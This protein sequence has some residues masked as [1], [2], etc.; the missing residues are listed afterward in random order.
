MPGVLVPA[1]RPAVALEPSERKTKARSIICV[2]GSTPERV[3]RTF[4]GMDERDRKLWTALADGFDELSGVT[5]KIA[6][7]LRGVASFSKARP[8]ERE[9]EPEPIAVFD[10]PADELTKTERKLLTALVQLGKAS[11]L[12]MVGVV[13]QLS[14]TAGHVTKAL[15]T[16]RSAGYVSG[17]VSSL[18][19]TPAGREAVGTV[20]PLPRGNELL[21]YWCNKLGATCG[22]L[23]RGL[24]AP[25]GTRTLS[26]EQLGAAAGL[27]YTAGHVTKALATLRRM[28]FIAGDRNALSLSA[29]LAAALEPSFTVFDTSNGRSVKVNRRGQRLDA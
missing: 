12:A 25:T 4:Q 14:H 18:A 10:G 2:G 26:L 13:A 3:R 1:S 11:P 7:A 19:A 8:T 17:K 24:R 27:S 9:P 22:K 15:A 29:E 20:P 28:E 6:R 5:G 23:L 16:L 21:E